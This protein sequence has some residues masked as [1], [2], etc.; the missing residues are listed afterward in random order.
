MLGIGVLTFN[1][2]LSILLVTLT[3]M[4]GGTKVVKNDSTR[5][6]VVSMMGLVTTRA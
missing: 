1:F 2:L 4:T 3:R 5:L 6:V